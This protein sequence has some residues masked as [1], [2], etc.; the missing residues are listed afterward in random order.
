MHQVNVSDLNPEIWFE[1]LCL[2]KQSVELD[3]SPRKSMHPSAQISET[4]C[5]DLR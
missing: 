3:I 1:I 5:E 4:F 2:Q